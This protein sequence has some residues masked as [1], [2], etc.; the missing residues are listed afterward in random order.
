MTKGQAP[1]A[2]FRWASVTHA[3]DVA[4]GQ[5]PTVRSAWLAGIPSTRPAPALRAPPCLGLTV[6]AFHHAICCSYAR[7]EHP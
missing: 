2:L 7:G 4:L 6:R 1:C 3:A 5:V